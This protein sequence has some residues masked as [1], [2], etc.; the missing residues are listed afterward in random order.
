MR[1]MDEITEE[2]AEVTITER[3]HKL[4]EIIKAD[5]ERWWRNLD[6]GEPLERNVGEML[7]LVHSEISEALEGH[8][9]ALM[10]DHLPHRR[11]FTVELA[12]AIIRILDIAAHI[13]PELPEALMEKL[14]YNRRREDHKD[15]AR[16]ASNGKKY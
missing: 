14:A 12:D 11:M 7:A 5:N 6:T 10:D 13:A 4:M 3:L 1:S 9:K 8:R 16:K 2:I 15:E